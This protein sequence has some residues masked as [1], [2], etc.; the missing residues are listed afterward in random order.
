MTGGRSPRRSLRRMTTGTPAPAMRRA[1][2]ATAVG[3]L[4]VATFAAIGAGTAATAQLSVGVVAGLN[5]STATGSGSLEAEGRTGFMLGGTTT[6]LVSETISLRPEFYISTKGSRF[7]TGPRSVDFRTMDVTSVQLPV[8][9]QLHTRPGGLVRPHL[10]AGVSLGVAVACRIE[11]D[12]CSQE[13]SLTR[14]RFES[15]VVVGAEVEVGGAAVGARYEAGLGP[16]GQFSWGTD[17]F[18]GVLSFTARYHVFSRGRGE[19]Q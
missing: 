3:V 5:R 9:V 12:D 16:A 14:E 13:E 7:R 19:S 15:G 4:A 6:I 1:R 18:H 17:I 2:A 11:A 8:L 10:L